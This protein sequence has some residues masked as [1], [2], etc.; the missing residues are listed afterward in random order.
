MEWEDV[1]TALACLMSMNH[2]VIRNEG[3]HNERIYIKLCLAILITNCLEILM[4]NIRRNY[5][6]SYLQCNAVAHGWMFLHDLR[7]FFLFLQLIFF[8]Y[9]LHPKCGF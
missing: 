4:G 8:P 1:G 5:R 3:V 9:F 7:F 6:Y 2:A